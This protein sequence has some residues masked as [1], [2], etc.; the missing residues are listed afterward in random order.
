MKEEGNRTEMKIQ[1]KKERSEEKKRRDLGGTR[2]V[3]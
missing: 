3:K 2:Q 1:E